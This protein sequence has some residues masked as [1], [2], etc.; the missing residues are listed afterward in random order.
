LNKAYFEVVSSTFARLTQAQCE[1]LVERKD[2]FNRH[3]LELM[4]NESFWLSFSG[5]TGK[6]DSVN[7]RYNGFA[8]AVAATLNNQM[9]VKGI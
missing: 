7:R 3:V 8:K 1:C 5:G 9:E 4:E 2:L 6:K